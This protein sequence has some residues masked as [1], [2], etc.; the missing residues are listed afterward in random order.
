MLKS[1]RVKRRTKYNKKRKGFQ[2]TP[3]WKEG[4]VNNEESVNS[5]IV[6]IEIVNNESV[7][8][9]NQNETTTE[10]TTNTNPEEN[11]DQTGDTSLLTTS[12]EKIVD[13]EAS[14]P[15]NSQEK[16]SGYRIV[17]TEILATVFNNT[18]CPECVNPTL[19]LGEHKSRKQ[20]MASMLFITCSRCPYS[21]D[22]ATSRPCKRGY[23]INRRAV[24]T[25]RSLGQGYSGLQK[26]TSLMNMP[27]PMTNRNYDKLITKLSVVS[28]LVAEETMVDAAKDVTSKSLD[29]EPVNTGVSVDGAWQRR[30]HA[31]LNGVVTA[32]S[33]ENGKILD[34]EPMS[35]N[36]KSHHSMDYLIESDPVTYAN[37]MNSHICSYNYKGSAPG[38][39]PAGAQRIFERSIEKYNLRYINYLGDGDSKSYTSVKNIYNGVSVNKLECVGHYQKR[40]GTRLRKLKK[41][42]KGL[43]G[44]GRLTDVTIDRLQNYFGMAIRQNAGNLKLMQS[45]AR[46]TLFHVASS[47]KNNYHNPHCPLGPNSWCRFNRDKAL[48]TKAYKPGPGL[49][50]DIIAKLK[51]I[52]AELTN[53]INLKKCLHGKTQNRNESFNAMIWERIPKSTYVSLTQLQLGVYDAVA[54]FNIGRKASV[55]IYEKLGMIP[56]TYTLKGCSNLNK[57]RLFN[58]KYKANEHNKKRRKKLRAK[59]MGKMDKDLETEG[60]LYEAGGF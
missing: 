26:F 19:N 4:A 2:G 57:K 58:A 33:L 12:R 51:P 22:F 31:S 6:N 7:N 42:V 24:Y 25:F 28:K 35:R 15:K 43:G 52:F 38:M 50:L 27:Q 55:L 11:I 8:I 47:E 20:G 10:L 1:H 34:V 9:E 32:I 49:P 5:E 40:I 29:T 60:V 13:I 59:K 30:G 41:T 53:E 56:G 44:R 48:N 23:D 37:W 16:I 21:Y 18:L 46:A 54:N 39:E 17:D 36:C 14:T 45:T 3:Y